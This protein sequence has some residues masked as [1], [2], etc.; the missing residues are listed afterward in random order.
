V[1]N[2][3]IGPDDRSQPAIA[4]VRSHVDVDAAA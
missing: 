2:G 1:I 3:A 4:T